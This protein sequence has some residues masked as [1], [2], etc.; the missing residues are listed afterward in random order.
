MSLQPERIF[1]SAVG[2]CLYSYWCQYNSNEASGAS[3]YSWL[4]RWLKPPYCEF[5]FSPSFLLR[6]E[7]FLS[8]T[9]RNK[10]G[11]GAWFHPRPSPAA[12]ADGHYDHFEFYCRSRRSIDTEQT[13]VPRRRKR[14]FAGC[15]TR[16]CACTGTLTSG[17]VYRND[18]R[19][20]DARFPAHE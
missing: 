7:F 15:E 8:K 1:A 3:I 9:E 11:S 2:A 19:G 18:A 5:T 17:N 16:T 12:A 6:S 13:I 4:P 14:H 20:P 10:H